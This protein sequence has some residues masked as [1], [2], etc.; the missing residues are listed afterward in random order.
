MKV[1]IHVKHSDQLLTVVLLQPL[2]LIQQASL[3][4]ALQ[5]QASLLTGRY[6]HRPT[7][8]SVM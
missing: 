6:E 8:K 2:I 4:D 7:F 3:D 1:K 5:L